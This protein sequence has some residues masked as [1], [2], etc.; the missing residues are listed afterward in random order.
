[1]GSLAL[2]AIGAYPSYA[3]N[4]DQGLVYSAVALVLCLV[5]AAGTLVWSG[6]SSKRSSEQQLLSMLGGT[7]VR[8]TVVLGVS[9]ALYTL[10]PY[11]NYTRFWVWVLFFYLFTLAVE[12]ALLMW[13]RPTTGG[14]EASEERSS[15]GSGVAVS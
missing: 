10:I 1:M 3:L 8:M 4:G 11:F 7:G 14:V 13:E 9:L 15:S 2:W 12:I 5:P 6:W